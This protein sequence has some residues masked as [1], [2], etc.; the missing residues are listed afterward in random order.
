MNR[1]RGS[2]H[3]VINVSPLG[4]CLDS[5]LGIFKGGLFY[6]YYYN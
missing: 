6:G 2:M 3:A 5:G 4:S 1:I